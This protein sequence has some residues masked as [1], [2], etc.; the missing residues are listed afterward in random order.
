MTKMS[1]ESFSHVTFWVL[2]RRLFDVKQLFDVE[3]FI[4]FFSPMS[5]VLEVIEYLDLCFRMVFLLF[6][7]RFVTIKSHHLREYFE[8]FF[9]LASKKVAN[10]RL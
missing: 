1:M 6:T 8:E 9:P 3:T 5:V 10:S 7:T 4:A 2:I